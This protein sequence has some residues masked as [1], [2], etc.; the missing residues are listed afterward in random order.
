M[1]E[2][3]I[4]AGLS[5]P[6]RRPLLFL[7]ATTKK[8]VWVPAFTRHDGV[9]VAAHYAMVHVADHHDEHQ[10]VAGQ[11]SHSQKTAHAQLS[12][13]GWFQALPHDHKVAVLLEHAT[14]IQDKASAA[15]VL[16]TFKKKILAGSA[17]SNAEWKAFDAADPDKKTAIE[18]EAQVESAATHVKLVN[19]YAKWQATQPTAAVQPTEAS[20]PAV[21]ASTGLPQTVAQVAK[22]PPEP[23]PDKGEPHK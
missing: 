11:G 23:A 2:P 19:G 21:A 16:S 12:K 20:A 15:A 4:L 7:K 6:T 17:P 8:Q 1:S 3:H 10:I 18:K 5:W 22:K 9:V 13:H 14:A